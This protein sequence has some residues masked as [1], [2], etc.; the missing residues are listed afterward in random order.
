MIF[1]AHSDFGLFV[2]KEHLKNNFGVLTQEHYSK[3][4][5]GNV[6]VEVLTVG[7]D[8]SFWG[9]NFSKKETVLKTISAIKKEI[10]MSEDKFFLI[11][12]KSDFKNLKTGSIG[13]ILALEGTMP[14]FRVYKN[15]L[16]E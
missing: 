8:F 13:I 12:S 7:G 11:Q 10:E 4:S 15:I 3:L 2:F 14:L 5:A 1:D 16:T 6:Y 9:I